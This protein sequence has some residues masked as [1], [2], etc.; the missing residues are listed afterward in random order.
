M[1]NGCHPGGPPPALGG[2]TL[3]GSTATP[4]PT[5]ALVAQLLGKLRCISHNTCRLL[6]KVATIISTAILALITRGLDNA[7]VAHDALDDLCLP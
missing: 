4:T 6:N 5:A 7:L 2:N 1:V 3:P